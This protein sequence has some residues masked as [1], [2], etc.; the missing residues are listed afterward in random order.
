MTRPG[1]SIVDG[2]PPCH[3]EPIGRVGC[4]KGMKAEGKE[5]KTE[6]KKAD[7]EFPVRLGC[8]PTGWVGSIVLSEDYPKKELSCHSNAT[9]ETTFPSHHCEGTRPIFPSCG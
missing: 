6:N 3:V 2:K 9:E 5:G 8:A 1:L 7:R 4:T